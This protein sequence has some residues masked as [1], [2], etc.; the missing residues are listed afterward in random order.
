MSE[1]HPPESS[2]SSSNLR[3]RPAHIGFWRFSTAEFLVAL[4]LL[5]IGAPFVESMPYGN[6]IEAVLMTLVLV[7]EI[8]RAH[9]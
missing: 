4:I 6:S 2:L 5:F 8:G 1:S 9:V 7:S 3:A